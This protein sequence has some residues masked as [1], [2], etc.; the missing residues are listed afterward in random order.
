MLD[1]FTLCYTVERRW[2]FLVPCE[3]LQSTCTTTTSGVWTRSSHIRH[4]KG[5]RHRSDADK[6]SP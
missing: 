3:I 4:W 1:H 6:C 5:W 2:A